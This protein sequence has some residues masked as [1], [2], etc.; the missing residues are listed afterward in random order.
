MGKAGGMLQIKL[1][2]Q[3]PPTMGMGLHRTSKELVDH[4]LNLPPLLQVCLGAERNVFNVL[5]VTG[6]TA[7]NGRTPEN[8]LCWE[9]VGDLP[10]NQVTTGDIPPQPQ[11]Q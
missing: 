7:K 8:Y 11:S 5:D 9:G 1:P 2:I 3:L 6:V 10:P 4:I